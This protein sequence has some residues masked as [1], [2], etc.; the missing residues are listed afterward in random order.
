MA[1]MPINIPIPA[2]SAVASYSYNEITSG[3]GYIRFYL[4]ND[5][6]DYAMNDNKIYSGVLRCMTIN[7]SSATVVFTSSIFNSPRV[8]NGNAYLEFSQSMNCSANR[9]QTTGGVLKLVSDGVTTTIGTFPNVTEVRNTGSTT[10]YFIKTS[11]VTISNINIKKGD[12]LTL[13]VTLGVAGA[14]DSGGYCD[15]YIVTAGQAGASSIALP[16]KIQL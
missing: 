9:T 2:E 1:G 3:Q 16:F 15:P 11:R 10:Q 6:V 8:L 12:Y 14:S 7:N 4:F 5:G 13:D